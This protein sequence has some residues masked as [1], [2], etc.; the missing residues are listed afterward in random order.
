MGF[1]VFRT[2]AGRKILT[3]SS[4]VEI[5]KVTEENMTRRKAVIFDMDGVIID[6][7]KFWRQAESEVFTSL[8]VCVTDELSDLTKSM[9]PSEVTKFWY[10][11][12]PWQDVELTIVENLVVSRVAELIKTNECGISGV[13]S[14]IEQLKNY[15][16]KIGLATNSPSIII[17]IVLQKMN[18][19]HLFDI[20]FSADNV[21][22][23]KPNP[24]IYIKTAK[25]LNIEPTNC[26]VIEDSYSGMIAAKAAGMKVI[27]FTNGKRNLNLE[28]V[29]LVINK[30]DTTNQQISLLLNNIGEI[31]GS[32]I[33]EAKK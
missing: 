24:E 21:T 26:I 11:K 10:D 17:P 15:N 4:F 30:F 3:L 16:Y 19:S 33:F 13:K 12:F 9:T 23:G 18:I 7:E 8:G 14:F 5:N 1:F 25:E 20:L 27:A 28:F 29:D 2:L 32:R 31:S 6:S 22:T